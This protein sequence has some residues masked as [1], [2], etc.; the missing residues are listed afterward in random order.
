MKKRIPPA[1]SRSPKSSPGR[2]SQ[3]TRTKKLDGP[4]QVL[5]DRVN[6]VMDDP[7]SASQ[8]RL[9]WIVQSGPEIEKTADGKRLRVSTSKMRFVIER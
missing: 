3:R 1:L 7:Q 6:E 4:A 9:E 2:R 8:P 5:I